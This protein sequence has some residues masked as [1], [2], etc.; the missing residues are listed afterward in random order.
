[1]NFK[2]WDIFE[3]GQTRGSGS[4]PNSNVAK[5][6]SPQYLSDTNGWRTFGLLAKEDKA[7]GPPSAVVAGLRGAGHESGRGAGR[8]CSLTSSGPVAVTSVAADCGG[9]ARAA[10]SPAA[11]V[12]LLAAAGVHDLKR[13][14][15]PTAGGPAASKLALA[16]TSVLQS[17]SH[18]FATIAE[19]RLLAFHHRHGLEQR[20]T[21][22]GGGVHAGVLAM[23]RRCAQGVVGSS[24]DARGARADDGGGADGGA[25][26]GAG[27]SGGGHGAG[28]CAWPAGGKRCRRAAQTATPRPRVASGVPALGRNRVARGKALPGSRRRALATFRKS[29]SM[30]GIGATLED[31]RWHGQG[32]RPLCTS[33]GVTGMLI[34]LKARRDIADC[35]P[36]RPTSPQAWLSGWPRSISLTVSLTAATKPGRVMLPPTDTEFPACPASDRQQSK[37]ANT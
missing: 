14:L 27:G 11:A 13:I 30:L 3:W 4:G 24:G 7:S 16:A 21:S 26:G 15:G 2:F 31:V 9:G 23:A 17:S 22:A 36:R 18:L 25:V 1:M 19:L 33:G 5:C 12:L 20:I 10:S 8:Y 29:S 28:A 34:F 32:W 35:E 37:P 6:E